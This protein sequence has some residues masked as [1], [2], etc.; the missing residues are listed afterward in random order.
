MH[1]VRPAEPPA[2]GDRDRRDQREER[3]GDEQRE[4][5]LLAALGVRR[6]RGGARWRVAARRACQSGWPRARRQGRTEV[7]SRAWGSFPRGGRPET[8]RA[9]RLRHRNL[10]CRRLRLEPA[11]GGT[12][13]TERTGAV[14]AVTGGRRPGRARIGP[15]TR[16][17][18]WSAASARS[19]GPGRCRAVAAPG[20]PGSATVPLGVDTAGGTA[21]RVAGVTRTR[22]SRDVR[23]GVIGSRR[24]LEPCGP[25]RVGGRSPGEQRGPGG[26]GEAP[27]AR[28]RGERGYDRKARGRPVLRRNTT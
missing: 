17:A 12:C 16:S 14:R 21:D 25:V 26:P 10:R 15:A 19:A 2:P 23:P 6:D 7:G 5:D 20:P 13:A 11:P 24:P 18:H 8:G 4:R 27:R 1:D 3:D 22:A 28:V 9:R